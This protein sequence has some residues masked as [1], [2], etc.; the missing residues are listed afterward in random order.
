M[1]NET[2]IARVI[3]FVWLGPMPTWAWRNVSLFADI[4]PGWAIDLR[5]DAAELHPSYRAAY[6][7][8]VTPQMQSAILR[9]DVLERE[10]G[11]YFDTDIMPLRPIADIEVTYAIGERLFAVAMAGGGVWSSY[12]AAGRDCIAWPVI[13][14]ILDA[15][16]RP[17]PQTYAAAL[18]TCLRQVAPQTMCIANEVDFSVT[19]SP[20]G[21]HE[22]YLAAQSGAPLPATSACLLHGSSG[23][24][25]VAG[26]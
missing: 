3:H 24:A 23:V 2:N 26:D 4:N 14:A 21:D 18:L 16:S 1:T 6:A 17:P 13:H 9:L 15:S 11:W 25:A 22:L 12:L 7:A 5:R 10:G 8:A 20:A 19:G